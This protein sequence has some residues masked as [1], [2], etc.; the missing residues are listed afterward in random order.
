MEEGLI[1]FLFYSI[2]DWASN[3]RLGYIPA[4]LK[5][6]LEERFCLIRISEGP[7]T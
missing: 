7:D 3:D 6:L 4:L 5:C 2:S 1:M